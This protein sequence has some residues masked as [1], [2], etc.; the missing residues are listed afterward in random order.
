MPTIAGPTATLTVAGT[1]A[2][3]TVGVAGADPL[4][5]WVTDAPG[6]DRLLRIPD[7]AVLGVSYSDGIGRPAAASVVVD[8]WWLLDD[9]D[10]ESWLVWE[11]EVAERELQI[12][13]DG[14][15]PFWGPILTPSHKPGGASKTVEAAN[16]DH[17]MGNVY[18]AGGQGV[19]S[20]EWLAN[21]T[22]DQG[23]TGWQILGPAPTLDPTGGEAGG[24]AVELSNGQIAQSVL[25]TLEPEWEVLVRARAYVDSSV[26]DDEVLLR[27]SCESLDFN[28]TR[29]VRAGDVT[30]D[31]WT[32]IAAQVTMRGTGAPGKFLD[33]VLAG[34]STETGMVKIDD[35]TMQ[36]SGESLGVPGQPPRARVLSQRLAFQSVINGAM[37][38]WRIHPSATL[39]G[40][41][42]NAPWAARPDVPV[43]EALKHLVDAGD[44]IEWGMVLTTTQRIA[45][46]TD[47][48]GVEHDPEVLTLT[49]NG[50]APNVTVISDWSKG[51]ER[52]VSQW[53]VMSE[54]GFT[55]TWRDPA[56]FPGLPPLQELVHAEV[57]TAVSELD[58]KAE[59]L[60]RAA[61]PALVE[62]M[63][64]DV[65]PELMTT[66]GSGDRVWLTIDDG[67]DSY[68]GWVRIQSRT[69]DPLGPGFG[70][71]V[72][73]WEP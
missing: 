12:V 9:E 3:A 8:R 7:D 42:I 34:D 6:G 73:R 14:R 49:P 37:A 4:E 51:V 30:R 54:E 53:V 71:T 45:L 64:L 31:Q 28:I 44:G 55:G 48:W 67:P 52:P 29:K 57:G 36:V 17:P 20:H 5:V 25:F 66:L 23:L 61:A 68:D 18:V 10:P 39:E 69:V 22:F 38:P 56:R 26:P 58:Q 41:V 63:T 32:W 15:V 43:S 60:G 33:V 1:G 70:V 19:W 47:L 59:A 13:H 2:L 40:R 46:M 35:V 21:P 72:T 11:L 16:C 24:P 50:P 65:A 62:K 27:L